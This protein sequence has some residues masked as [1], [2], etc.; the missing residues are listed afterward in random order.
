MF[1][2]FGKSKT[3]KADVI[4]AIAAGLVGI[5][6]AADT[7]KEYKADQADDNKENEK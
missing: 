2:F 3:T 7:I 5:W 1:K 4:M 6:K